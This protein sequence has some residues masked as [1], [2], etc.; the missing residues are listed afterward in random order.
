MYLF[1]YPDILPFNN[2][3][4][5]YPLDFT[6]I[7]MENLK[8]YFTAGILWILPLL[9]SQYVIDQSMISI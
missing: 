6:F 8:F 9:T 5:R 1:F 4:C 3:K 7:A 2:E